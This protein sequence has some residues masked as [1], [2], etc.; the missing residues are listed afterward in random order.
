MFLFEKHALSEEEYTY[1]DQMRIKAFPAHFH[2]AFELINI[3]EGSMPI[4]IDNKKFTLKPSDLAFIFPNQ[5]HSA[6]SNESFFGS[7]FVF[8]PETINDFYLEHKDLIPVNNVIPMPSWLDF[9]ELDAIYRKK[10]KIYLLCDYLLSATEM[11][12]AGSSINK[13]VLQKLF[14]Y[15]DEHY[16][17]DCSLK[18]AA[19][20]LQYDY[21]YLSK[22]FIKY[23]GISFTEYLNSYRIS[24][25]CNM[26]RKNELSISEIA[27]RCGYSNLRTFHRNFNKMMN[28]APQ[29]YK[30]SKIAGQ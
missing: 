30:K 15:I 28:C 16:G 24:Q 9:T 20:F 12:P 22:L 10:G 29:V 3:I 13:T 18:D 26:L 14:V 19:Q 21:A 17:E 7:V 4:I 2:R 23:T 27:D 1:Y 11:E 8:S 5:I 25:A 6:S